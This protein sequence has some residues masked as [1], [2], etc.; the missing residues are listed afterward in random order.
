VVIS[1]GNVDKGILKIIN[2]QQVGT[3][4]T[5]TS[6]QSLPVDVQA[7]KGTNFLRYLSVFNL[8]IL[9]FSS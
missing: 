9:E 1:N 4:F 8:K 5:K 7:V 3:F 6:Q 2:G